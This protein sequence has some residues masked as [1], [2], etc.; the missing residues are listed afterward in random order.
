MEQ[1]VAGNTIIGVS[2]RTQPVLKSL[3]SGDLG[4]VESVAEPLNNNYLKIRAAGSEVQRNSASILINK[5][6][7]TRGYISNGLTG[8]CQDKYRLTLTAN[9]QHVTVGT[10]TIGFDNEQGLMADDLFKQEI[11]A[12]RAQG[13]KVCEFTKLAMDATSKSK[14][15]LASL[16]HVAYIYA[17]RIHG[18]QDLVIEVNPRHVAYYQRVLGFT[19]LGPERL[20]LRVNA[21]AVLLRLN[22]TYVEEQ[23]G[24]FGGSPEVCAAERS[25][26]P[27]VFSVEEEANIVGRLCGLVS[28]LKDDSVLN[29]GVDSGA[30]SR[31]MN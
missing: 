27:Y 17:H 15:A 21:P 26:Y 31:R 29:S 4:P 28:V 12:L 11:D 24:K 16:F 9:E 14:R 6:Y 1:E 22:F 25:L 23:I 2:T 30:L 3:L 19:V 5:M 8:N 18:F 20:N 7:A 10:L 13:R